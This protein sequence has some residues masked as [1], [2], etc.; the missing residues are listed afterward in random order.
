MSKFH[1]L[2][3]QDVVR[4][5]PDCVT[6]AIEVPP[7]LHESF[8]F[9][10]G[11]Y[12]TFRAMID[13]QDVRRSYSICSSPSEHV[14]RVAI[15]AVPG[16]LFSNYANQ[17][18]KAGDL[19]E[20]MPPMGSFT[21]K[22]DSAAPHHYVAFASGSGITPI[23]SMIKD[24]LEREADSSFTLFY[25]NKNVTSVIFKE[26]LEGLKN[27]YLNRF[28]IFYIF[29]R[30]TQ[31]I[32]LFNGRLDG[33]KCAVFSKYFFDAEETDGYFLCGPEEM[34]VSVSEQLKALGVDKGKIHFE[35]FTTPGA[36]MKSAI[37]STPPVESSVNKD[38]E[39][40]I[41]VVLDG[42]N[43]EFPLKTGGASILDAAL[44]QGADL[45]FACKGGVCCTCKAKVQSGEV[46]MDVNYG[47]EPDEVENGFILTCQAHPVSAAVVVDFDAHY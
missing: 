31:E 26:E 21:I 16:G 37:A 10:A 22:A 47:L 38:F 6:L 25:G 40:L 33:A 14:W 23:L 1:S 3:I 15:K 43:I 44:K 20:V 28:S 32:D 27:T 34:I 8:E 42:V 17:T 19:L 41:T 11:Q 9:R 2:R 24:V 5:T 30:E 29:S 35:L 46:V 12:L 13:G 7:S 45:P 4:E 36:A 39:S 18:L